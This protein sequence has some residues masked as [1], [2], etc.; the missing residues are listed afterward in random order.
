MMNMVDLWKMAL[1]EVWIPR[2]SAL[3]Y[4]DCPLLLSKGSFW[5]KCVFKQASVC[6][7]RG[8]E[9]HMHRRKRT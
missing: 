4:L 1:E 9:A 7:P 8:A 3:L 2:A 5:V 6:K